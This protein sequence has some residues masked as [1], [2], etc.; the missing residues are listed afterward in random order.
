MSLDAVCHGD[1]RDKSLPWNKV[2]ARAVFHRRKRER[3][4]LGRTMVP[5]TYK[6]V[7]HK[8][9]F[10]NPVTS[11]SLQLW[12]R[13]VHFWKLSLEIKSA[14]RKKVPTPSRCLTFCPG[15]RNSLEWNHHV[16]KTETRITVPH[17]PISLS[18]DTFLVADEIVSGL[19]WDMNR[20]KRD[21]DE[22]SLSAETPRISLLIN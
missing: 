1:F 16:L 22:Y 12:G 19:R 9:N 11:G 21:Q 6:H 20:H 7:P 3:W 18:Q 10:R 13:N 14:P 5:K 2:D 4:C 15:A 17:H 8:F